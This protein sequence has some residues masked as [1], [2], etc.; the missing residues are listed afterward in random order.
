MFQDNV[1]CFTPEGSVIKLPKDATP[2]DFAYAVHTQ[3]GD[4]AIGCKI[5][6][7]EDSLQSIL[8]NGD[9]IKI[10]TSDKISPSLHW[11]SSAKTG[12]ARAA[13]RRYWHDKE[14][15]KEIDKKY[16]SALWL[17]L[18]DIPGKLGEVTSLIGINKG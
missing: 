1:F 3:I 10:I 7:K 16:N 6:G 13:I 2:I 5:N 18:P 4:T 11:L 9:M 8:H 14:P 15:K 17:S 12:K